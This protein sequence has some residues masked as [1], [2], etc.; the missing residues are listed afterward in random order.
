[1]KKTWS[2]LDLKKNHNIPQTTFLSGFEE[3]ILMGKKMNA[4]NIIIKKL[5]LHHISNVL[6]T[7]LISIWFQHTLIK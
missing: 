4:Y 6:V 7:K 2:H 3:T 1:M 5:I